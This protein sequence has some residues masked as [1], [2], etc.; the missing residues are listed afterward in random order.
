MGIWSFAHLQTQI[1]NVLGVIFKNLR[2]AFALHSHR[3]RASSCLARSNIY[4]CPTSLEPWGRDV[5]V[6]P[7]TFKSGII[8]LRALTLACRIPCCDKLANGFECCLIFS[9]KFPIVRS[10]VHWEEHMGGP[11]WMTSCGKCISE[12]MQGQTKWILV[13]QHWQ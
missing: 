2:N 8:A 6:V 9:P 5:S 4:P 11:M 7:S 13:A 12:W 10:K 1:S 3:G